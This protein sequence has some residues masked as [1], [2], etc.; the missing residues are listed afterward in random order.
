MILLERQEIV[1]KFKKQKVQEVYILIKFMYEYL[2]FLFI[3]VVLFQSIS[4]SFVCSTFMIAY[5]S[6]QTCRWMGE[7]GIKMIK[8]KTILTIYKCLDCYGNKSLTN[9]NCSLW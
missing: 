4:V 1:Q 2:L 6:L 7:G 5:L 9:L 8:N 3:I